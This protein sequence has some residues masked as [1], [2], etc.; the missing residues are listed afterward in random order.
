MASV[1]LFLGILL[2]AAIVF[3]V[4]AIFAYNRRLDKIARGEERDTHNPIPEPQTT[5]SGV[6]R[7]ILMGLVV[8]SFLM[9]STLNGKINALQSTL[10]RM[11]SQQNGLQSE[12]MELKEQI[13]NQDKVVWGFTWEI[14]AP[15]YV[16]QTAEVEVSAM[17]R[18]FSEN[19]A[20]TFQMNGTQVPLI[21]DEE[22]TFRGTFTGH[23]FEKYT[24]PMILVTEN[25]KTVAEETE[26]PEEIFWNFF[27]MPGL[28][29]G[30]ESDV[31]PGGKMKYS[32]WYKVITDRPEEIASASITYMSDGK[33]LKTM[34]ITEEAH[35]LTEI[36]LEKGLDVKKDLT[37]RIEIT[38]KEGYKI[39]NQQAVIFEASPDYEEK[40]SLVIL[41]ASGKTVWED[42]FK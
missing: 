38:T 33:D 31:T 13:E 9:I 4:G 10:F 41:D 8:A 5:V 11:E 40:D 24:N 6:Y 28:E 36:T 39:V 18:E 37:F 17:L 7:V 15:D 22:G 42:D 25:G 29:C 19:T 16:S 26:F 2:V 1:L 14:G 12:L 27:P 23:F 30:F 35:N 32:G 3:I 20:V 34:D 21:A